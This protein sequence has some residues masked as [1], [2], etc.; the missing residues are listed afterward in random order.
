MLSP[1]RMGGPHGFSQFD[2]MN[3]DHA[4]EVDRQPFISL[5]QFISEIYQVCPIN[6]W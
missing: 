6:F 2:N 3:A 5:L 4:P 1:Y